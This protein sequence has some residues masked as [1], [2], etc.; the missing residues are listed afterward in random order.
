MKRNAAN[1]E[2]IVVKLGMS[3]FT[4][5]N[6]ETVHMTTLEN[7]D[8]SK[9][10]SKNKDGRLYKFVKKHFLRTSGSNEVKEISIIPD[11]DE[12][13][14]ARRSGGSAA[15]R[16][17]NETSGSEGERLTVVHDMAEEYIQEL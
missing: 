11:G 5:V 8:F 16:S 1:N 10:K 7:N 3:Y 13:K 6:A 15:S 4:T 2:T 9:K 14:W 12:L 17:S